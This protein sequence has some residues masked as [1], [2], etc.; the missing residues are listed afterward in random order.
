[1]ELDLADTNINLIRDDPRLKTVLRFLDRIGVKVIERELLHTT[2]LP[3]LDLGPGCIYVDYG[4]LKYP[5]DMVH[6]AGHLAVTPSSQRALIGSAEQDKDWPPQG[7][8][9]AAILWSFA[10]A[11]ELDLPLDFVFH[12]DGYKDDSAWLIE[13]FEAGTYIGLPFLEWAGLSLGAVRAEK[14][15]KEAFPAMIRWMRE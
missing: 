4:R 13:T 8:E 7:E 2:F 14:E 3:G 1:M 15:G 5:G 6:E 10:A 11:R 12:G 9:I